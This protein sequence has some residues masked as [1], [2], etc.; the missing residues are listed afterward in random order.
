MNLDQME[1]SEDEL[2]MYELYLLALKDEP[3]PFDN[4]VSRSNRKDLVDITA[5]REMAWYTTMRAMAASV[6]DRTPRFVP[7]VGPA[8]SGKTHFYWAMKDFEEVN[9]VNWT[10]VYIPS[11]PAALRIPLHIYTCLLDEIG[12]DLLTTVA[13]NIVDQYKSK[14]SGILMRAKTEEILPFALRDYPGIAS[15]II[16]ALFIFGYEKKRKTI[17][18]RYLLGEALA[19]EEMDELGVQRIIEDDDLVLAAIR[20]LLKNYGKIVALYFDELEIPYRTRG[21]EAESAFLE[22]LK[23]IYNEMPNCFIISAC[24]IEMWPR[25]QETMDLAM[26]TR[27]EVEAELEP[28]KVE[29]LKEFYRLS[30]AHWWEENQNVDPP[31]TYPLFPLKPDDF[32]EIHQ[33]TKG[34]ARLSIKHIRAYLDKAI[35]G[36]LKEEAE[37]TPELEVVPREPEPKPVTKPVPEPIT[38]LVET[39]P[40][41]AVP[42]PKPEP[43]VEAVP[44]PISVE[45]KISTERPKRETPLVEPDIDKLPTELPGEEISEEVIGEDITIT[46]NPPSVAAG[47]L[48]SIEALAKKQGKSVEIEEGFS[49]KI[50]GKAK[51]IAGLIT[52]QGTKFGI[53]V[54]SVKSF[55]RK[56]G[57]AAYYALNRLCDIIKAGGIDKGIL[58]VPPETGGA[59][60]LS[61]L[62]A[63]S[64]NVSVIEMDEEIAEN[65]IRGGLLKKPSDKGYE[66]ARVLF[67]DLEK[68]EE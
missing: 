44:E 16:K 34:N 59:K 45:P 41:E 68:S 17:A 13:K 4:F 27:L 30:M 47:A 21:P 39:K 8:G 48:N 26:Q 20:I 2:E 61:L 3:T 29:D 31:A 35:M 37:V 56:G 66:I 25:V 5:P 53:D 65:F 22:H 62:E 19:E 42:E 18:E 51:K 32:I 23:R 54:P 52:Y 14:K 57:V 6:K 43:V 24:L 40:S 49:F 12:T 11:P 9:D 10:V 46:V 55:D 60:Y 33:R 1:L 50:E 36:R 7:L 15:D 28:F 58:I 64:E 38:P 67:P 63:N